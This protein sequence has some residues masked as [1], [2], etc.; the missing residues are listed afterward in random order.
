MGRGG[1]GEG[2][3]YSSNKLS[4]SIL[5]LFLCHARAQP[6]LTNGDEDVNEGG[7]LRPSDSDEGTEGFIED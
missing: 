3:T 5:S 2:K 6:S 7:R 4:K 1:D